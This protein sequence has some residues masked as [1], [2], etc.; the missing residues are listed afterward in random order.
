MCDLKLFI[1]SHNVPS[2]SCT[3]T[4]SAGSPTNA[5]RDRR[6]CTP[7]ANCWDKSPSTEIWTKH[8]SLRA[9]RGTYRCT[10]LCPKPL[11]LASGVFSHSAAWGRCLWVSGLRLQLGHRISRRRAGCCACGRRSC[12]RRRRLLLLEEVC[13]ADGTAVVLQLAQ[14]HDDALAV[15]CV[16]ARKHR[17][18]WRALHAAATTESKRPVMPS[19]VLSRGHNTEQT[20]LRLWLATH[21]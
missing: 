6:C 14:P 19:P 7:A 18:L 5:Q 16:L 21:P 4:T 10:T 1:S 17:S 3:E 11:P 2:R 12:C 8:V 13:P 9:C 15:E 20:A